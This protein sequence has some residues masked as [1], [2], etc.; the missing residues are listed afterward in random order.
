[1]DLREL[2]A[3]FDYNLSYLDVNERNTFFN[4]LC[5]FELK[6]K[7]HQI[8]INLEKDVASSTID[9]FEKAIIRL[10]NNEPIQYVLGFTNFFGLQI[11]VNRSVLIA[12]PETEE[13]V[14][15]AL[16]NFD[17]NQKLNILDLGT[18]S[19]CIS[20]ALS[21]HLPNSKV[22][23]LDIDSAALEL[24]N[25]N[26]KINNVQVSFFQADMLDLPKQEQ[27]FDLIVSNPPYVLEN[28]KSKIADN[29]LNFE[30]PIALFVKDKSP[31][32]FYYAIK[33]ILLSNLKSGGMCFLENNEAFGNEVVSLYKE[34]GLM[35]VNLRK[36]NYGKNRMIKIV[37]K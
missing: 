23:A 26:A 30:P 29:V 2:K 6:I 14:E 9:Y 24:A 8:A 28:E 37:R 4:W 16:E 34:N 17:E 12:R 21:K 31:L 15:W 19:G 20:I 1:M 27:K 32:V 18:G 3:H 5:A 25:L 36:D 7:P 10:K 35:S 33:K 13:L 22:F 11:N